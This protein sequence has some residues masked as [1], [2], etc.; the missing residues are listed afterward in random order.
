MNSGQHIRTSFV[1][2]P[3]GLVAQNDH[4]RILLSP[5]RGNV[6]FDGDPLTEATE[7][8]CLIRPL[9]RENIS[10]YINDQ[11]AETLGFIRDARALWGRIATGDH[12]GQIC[13]CIRSGQADIL[14]ADLEVRP[15]RL[16]YET[17]YQTMREDIQ[18]ISRELIYL[19]P[20]H[21]RITTHLT[22]TS[23]GAL[24]FYQVLDHLLNQLART[25]HAILKRPDR[26]LKTVQRTCAIDRSSGRDPAA[27]AHM[28]RSPQFWTSDATHI[29]FL[30]LTDSIGCTHVRETHCHPDIDTPLNRHLVAHLKR[31]SRRAQ[32]IAHTALGH[33][34]KTHL[35]RGLRLLPLP[36]ARRHDAMPVHLDAR[37]QTAFALIRALNRALAP[38]IGGPFDLSFRDTPT[39]YEYWIY[40][41][42]VHTLC[43]MGFIPI[44]DTNLFH[45][46]ERALSVSPTQGEPSAIH[47]Q[48]HTCHI[49]CLYNPTYT[50]ASGRALTHDLRPDI[51]IEIHAANTARALYA[52]D[53]KY[54]RED[55]NGTWIPMRQDIDKMHAYRDAIGQV[56]ATDFQRILKSAIVLFPGPADPAYHAHAFYTSLSHGIGGLPILPG[57]P[58][59]LS[60][61]KAYIAEHVLA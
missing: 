36:P 8:N 15:S 1:Q 37:Y 32:A 18:R 21:A 57:D 47:L 52:F 20:N 30:R 39:L 56:T 54:R 6:I 38:C 17:D 46:T 33:R 5:V 24:D 48:R 16:N 14:L 27:I 10:V 28:I 51:I 11:L 12:P 13:F 23:G 34:L 2:T 43:N 53:A 9:N 40:F 55:H 58:N 50:A 19:L 45:L 29:P 35:N 49:R 4:A 59:T 22:D 44:Q 7:C 3:E 61:L 31:L 42:L 41:T 25:L 26:H 60:G